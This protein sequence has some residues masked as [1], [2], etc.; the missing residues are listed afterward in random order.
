MPSTLMLLSNP[1]RPDPRVL[2]EGRALIAFGVKVH[3]IAW[4][5]EE[6][7]P[8]REIDEGLDVI[9][10]GPPTPAR[11][12]VKVL[13]RLP[14]FWL[15]A[16]RAMKSVSFDVVHAHDF[17][18]LPLGFM[19][20]RLARK[21]LLYDAHELYAKMI[22]HEVGPLSRLVWWWERRC[23]RRATA[24]I[25]VS[26]AL[27]NEISKGRK[28]RAR[29]VTTSQDPSILKGLDV[30]E[31]RRKYGLKGFVV[32]YLGSL[33]PGRFVEE[34]ASSFG[35]DE[36]VTMVVGGSGTLQTGIERA[37]AEKPALRFIGVVDTDEA[38]RITYASD[39]VIAMMDPSNP[40]N[41][42]GTPGK[43]INAMACGRPMITTRG[44]QIAEK[45]EKAGAGIVVP[46]DK[47]A[48]R[49]AV[50][51]AAKDPRNLAD[52]GKKGRDLY[53]REYSWE[54]SK[55]E[56]LKAYQALLGPF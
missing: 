30:G 15:R 28:D 39:L 18:T 38:L 44:L 40:N 22:E 2:I 27:A 35:P 33:E 55:N 46:Y 16:L 49:D 4:N 26:E 20:A 31:V 23:A 37:A 47:A 45:I 56:L 48:F 13:R 8:A 21:P 9:R 11:S 54:R 24:V 25:T 19:I 5:R 6:R 29:V 41:I 43:I 12:P 14:I 36:G 52:M 7:R 42:V 34:S 10:L 50:L 53:D 3:L 17:D 32:S 1:F 51:K